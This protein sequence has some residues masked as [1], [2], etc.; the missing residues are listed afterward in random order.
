MH[1]EFSSS[2]KVVGRGVM[3][4]NAFSWCAARNSRQQLQDSMWWPPPFNA[5]SRTP[6]KIGGAHAFEGPW[7]TTVVVLTHTHQTKIVEQKGVGPLSR[8]ET[9]FIVQEHKTV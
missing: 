2:V 8:D 9:C 1:L 7:T 6:A 4:G 3:G 5:I